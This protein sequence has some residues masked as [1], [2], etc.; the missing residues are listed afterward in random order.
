MSEGQIITGKN[1]NTH[2]II[3]KVHLSLIS[4]TQIPFQ[5][6]PSVH[7]SQRGNHN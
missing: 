1:N 6:T 3:L 4:T 7:F 5:Y 2:K